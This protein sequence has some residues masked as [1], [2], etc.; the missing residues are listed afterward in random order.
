MMRCAITSRSS[1]SIAAPRQ[2]PV[3]SAR[4]NTF[5]N[6]VA[7]NRSTGLGKLQIEAIMKADAFSSIVQKTEC[8]IGSRRVT[9]K[10]AYGRSHSIPKSPSRTMPEYTFVSANSVGSS[11]VYIQMLNPTINP[12]AAPARVPP[13]QKSPP[14]NAGSTCATP[15]N[16]MRPMDDSATVPP[17]TA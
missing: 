11:S 14:I 2:P 9:P 3:S 4:S 17:E 7:C 16:E 8:T 15:T 12:R 13:R 10:S 1:A 5:T 6:V